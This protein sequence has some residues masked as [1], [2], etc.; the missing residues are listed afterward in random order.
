MENRPKA[1]T[2]IP[3]R[4]G[5]KRVPRK[6][7]RLLGG[8]PLVCYTID[9]AVK[10]GCFNKIILSSNDD[11]VLSLGKEKGI[12]AERRPDELSGDHVRVLEVFKHILHQPEIYGT[13][14]VVALLWPTCPF[15]TANDII[16]GF[17]IP[18]FGAKGKLLEIIQPT[19]VFH[20][21]IIESNK[22][23]DNGGVMI[24]N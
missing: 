12:E 8:K 5:S 14:D 3:A 2:V 11:E 13:Y 17:T 6:N 7:L 20:R 19:N 10:S 1:L 23:Y 22:L 9:A 21:F 4:G 16:K 24:Y 15:R 18:Y